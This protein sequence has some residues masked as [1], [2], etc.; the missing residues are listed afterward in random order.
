MSGRI[1]LFA[2]GKSQVI[3]FLVLIIVVGGVIAAASVTETDKYCSSCHSMQPHSES[4][5]KGNHAEVSC[6]SCHLDA[7]F[8]GWFDNRFTIARMRKVERAGGATSFAK[9]DIENAWC[10][11]CHQSGETGKGTEELAIPHII[12]VDGM[13]IACYDCHSGQVHGEGDG[14]PVS[15]SHDKCNTCHSEWFEQSTADCAKC[16]I[17]SDVQATEKIAI[18]HEAHNFETCDYCH[19]EYVAGA[20]GEIGHNTCIA[21]HEE[22]FNVDNPSCG[23]CHLNLNFTETEDYIIPHEMHSS[24]GCETCHG[25]QVVPAGTGLGHPSCEGCH[26][27]WFEEDCTACHKW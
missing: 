16:H 20:V 23:S 19:V 26:A 6:A 25:D 15:I 1:S 10:L 8:K 7:G 17:K 21:C 12:H 24:F 4:L 18:P 5:A 13:E 27:E 3:I 2:R 22:L 11:R 9:I 14:E